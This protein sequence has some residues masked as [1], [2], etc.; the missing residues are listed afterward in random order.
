MPCARGVRSCPAQ[1][2]VDET[3]CGC[4]LKFRCVI[5]S[6]RFDGVALVERHR[7]VNDLLKE[8]METIHALSMKTWTPQQYETKKEKGQA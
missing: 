7:M 4:G 3:S 1:E 8:E 2:V 5:V 6:E